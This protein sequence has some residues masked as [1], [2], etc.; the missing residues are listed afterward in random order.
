MTTCLTQAQQWLLEIGQWAVLIALL[1]VAIIGTGLLCRRAIWWTVDTV[2]SLKSL[3]DYLHWKRR[4]T[5]PAKAC[6][7]ISMGHPEQCAE[8]A[9]CRWLAKLDRMTTAPDSKT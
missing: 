6:N 5:Q 2:G 9:G 3:A 7:C 4:C 1:A 8:Q